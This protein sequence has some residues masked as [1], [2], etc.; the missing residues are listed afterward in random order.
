VSQP[1][2]NL[3]R[4]LVVDTKP[5]ITLDLHGYVSPTLLHPSTPPHN[6]NNEYDLFIKHALP[7]ALGIEQA[8]KDLGY[9]ETQRARIPFRDDEPG[10]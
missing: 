5:I 8:L 10:V 6:V 3:I 4:E 9:A 2:T 7:N 1:E